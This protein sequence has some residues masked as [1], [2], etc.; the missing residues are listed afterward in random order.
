MEKIKVEAIR[1]KDIRGKEN[2]YLRISHIERPPE[3]AVVM[4]VGEKTFAGVEK[5]LEPPKKNVK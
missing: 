3:E 5:L 1:F 4:N 2:L